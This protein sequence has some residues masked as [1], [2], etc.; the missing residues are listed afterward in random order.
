MEIK[1]RVEHQIVQVRLELREH[2]VEI[3]E[4]DDLELDPRV[5][6]AEAETCNL[7]ELGDETIDEIY[8]SKM[9]RPS[10]DVLPGSFPGQSRSV[11]R[12]SL[13]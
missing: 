9:C 6:C 12:R 10:L 13:R 4:I 8:S 5:G 3:D 2:E 7:A 11:L 1:V